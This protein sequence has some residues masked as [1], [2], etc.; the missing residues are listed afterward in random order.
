MKTATTENTK[1][2]HPL[3]SLCA[4]WRRFNSISA[5]NESPVVG[6]QPDQCSAKSSSDIAFNC[7]DVN[8]GRDDIDSFL[9][10]VRARHGCVKAA[11]NGPDGWAKQDELSNVGHLVAIDVPRLVRLVEALRSEVGMVKPNV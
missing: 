5:K 1:D 10:Q 6:F 8:V 7:F 11:W 3:T 9:L 4:L 2:T